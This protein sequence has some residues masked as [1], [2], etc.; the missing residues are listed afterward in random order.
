[1]ILLAFLLGTPANEIVLPMVVL[2]VSGSFGLETNDLAEGLTA[3][4]FDWE[5][6]LCTAIFFLFHWPCATTIMTIY[7]ETGSKKWTAFAVLL[8]TVVG[9]VLCV[10]LH[11]MLLQI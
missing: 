3:A 11:G 2:I 1:M 8:P 4:G 10:L 6:A 5:T 7:R 9:V